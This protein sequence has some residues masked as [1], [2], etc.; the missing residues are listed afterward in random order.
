MKVFLSWSGEKSRGVAE[1][2]R[3]WLPSVIQ[4][5]EPFMSS[6]DIAAG[7]RWQYLINEAL[8]GT[9]FGILCVTQRNQ[10]SRWLNFEAGAIAKAVESSRV[11]PLA[12]DLKVTD[13]RPP[14][15]QFHAKEA[16]KDG[17]RAVVRS[18]NDVC[19]T[20]VADI[21]EAFEVWWPKLD[22]HLEQAAVPDADLSDA[23]PIRSD[24]D[25][26]EEI[27]TTVRS[28][29]TSPN[30][31]SERQLAALG[32]RWKWLE[33]G[34]ERWEQEIADEVLQVAN[35]V[36]LSFGADAET[37]TIKPRSELVADQMTRIAAIG[38][39]AG[40]AKVDFAIGGPTGT[41]T[42]PLG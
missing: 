14:L 2:L 3:G 15:G 6:E 10:E 36:T 41:I 25:V 12:I 8:E 27:L 29:Q 31:R 5:L 11:V 1:A 19:S 26:L 16:S 42:I 32:N 35:E 33:D 20:P 24:R 30:P 39:R 23:E 17:L 18:L 13:I 34:R 28:Q 7:E 40:L 21:D 4:E 37:L 22:G 9:S 38:K